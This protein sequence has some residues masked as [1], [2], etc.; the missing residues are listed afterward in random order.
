M[1]TGRGGNY[2]GNFRALR[3]N[4]NAPLSWNYVVVF[5]IS[6]ISDTVSDGVTLGVFMGNSQR[7]FQRNS[8]WLSRFNRTGN[9]SWYDITFTL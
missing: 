5:V 2:H 6:G 1:N 8:F 4:R 9:S 7:R 3:T